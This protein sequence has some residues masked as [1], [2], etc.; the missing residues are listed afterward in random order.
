MATIYNEYISDE[1]IQIRINSGNYV[2]HEL[3]NIV[4]NKDGTVLI[5]LYDNFTLTIH[6]RKDKRL[7]IR[8]LNS[9]IYVHHVV[10]EAW[11]KDFIEKEFTIHHIDFNRENN[12]YSN[13]QKLSISE[14][15]KLHQFYDRFHCKPS[16]IDSTGFMNLD[17]VSL[18]IKSLN[19]EDRNFLLSSIYTLGNSIWVYGDI[20]EKSIA[21]Y[22]AY[23]DNM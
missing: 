7:K 3:L 6:I 19:L 9:N 21:Y 5:S 10:Y 1:E 4:T 14:H 8:Y 20:I 12:H 16:D 17:E 2:V 22:Y 18:Y 11:Y 13:L 23:W 15:S